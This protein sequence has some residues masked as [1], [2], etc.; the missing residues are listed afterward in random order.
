MLFVVI[1]RKQKTVA[2]SKKDDFEGRNMQS[3]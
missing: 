2:E 1:N 3:K